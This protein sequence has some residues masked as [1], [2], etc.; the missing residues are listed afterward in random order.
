MRTDKEL[1]TNASVVICG[2]VCTI[3]MANNLLGRMSGWNEPS[4]F[5]GFGKMTGL[6]YPILYFWLGMLIRSLKREPKWWFQLIVAGV[7]AFCLY[8][9]RHFAENWWFSG[10]L[11]LTMAGIGYLIPP[12]TIKASSQNHGWISL[13][14]IALSVY[15]YTALT[16]VKDRLLWGPIIPEH[17]DME[18]MMEV[19]LVNAEPMMVI[20]AT[21]FAVQFAFSHI[22]QSIGSKS[23]FKGIVAIPCVY[24]FLGSVS[25]LFSFR[26]FFMVNYVYFCPLM[27]FIV[28][29]ITI[30]LVVF[31][32]RLSRESRKQKEDRRSWKEIAKI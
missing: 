3:L 7:S 16:T 4:V 29:P 18:A 27:W 15:C 14:L 17:P 23:W 31:V 24:V 30:Y 12:L 21:Y 8:R 6:C 2:A 11:Y 32:V 26:L 10:F 9:Y 20:I 5:P 1:Y 13:A 19:I 22:A 28:Q 25:R